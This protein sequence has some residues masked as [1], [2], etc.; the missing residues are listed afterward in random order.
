MSGISKEDVEFLFIFLASFCARNMLIKSRAE[1][2]F[3]ANFLV[4]SKSS[5]TTFTEEI[6]GGDT[7]E[8]LEIIREGTFENGLCKEQFWLLYEESDE[9]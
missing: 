7:T 4:A 1:E 9:S 6:E 3:C 5:S 8:I 2:R